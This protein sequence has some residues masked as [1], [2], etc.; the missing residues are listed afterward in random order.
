M[1]VN[2]ANTAMQTSLPAVG[3]TA[4]FKDSRHRKNLPTEDPSA[5]NAELKRPKTPTH[6]DWGAEPSSMLA[7]LHKRIQESRR[8]L[9][10]FSRRPRSNL[11]VVSGHG[12]EEDATPAAA[13]TTT[14]KFSAYVK[15]PTFLQLV[16]RFLRLM[17]I[18]SPLLPL[19]P[20]SLFSATFRA[21]V[22][23]PVLSWCLGWCGPAF[24]KWGQWASTRR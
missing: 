8:P 19:A 14:T 2:L 13:A 4:A 22:F 7:V 24:I 21:G 17:L 18:F 23:Y 9:S 11:Q 12:R 5:F 20:L 16:S 6:R 3:S 1:A 10:F 15:P